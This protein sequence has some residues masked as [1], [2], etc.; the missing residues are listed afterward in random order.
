MKTFLKKIFVPPLASSPVSA[1]AET[2]LGHGIPIFMIHRMKVEGQS[3]N[4]I[5]PD[6]L[7]CC[8]RYLTDKGYTLVSLEDIVLS[9][10]NQISLPVKS[11]A[12]TMD[13]GFLDQAEIAAPLFLEFNC[14]LTFFVITGMLDKKLWPWDAQVSWI[15]DNTKNN[16]L[17]IDFEDELLIMTPGDISGRSKAREEIRNIIKEM[18]SEL[19]P[20]LINKLAEAADVQTPEA[21]PAAYQSMDWDM[22]RELES[23]GVRFAPHSITH[24]ILSKLRNKSVEE[25]IIGS[26]KTLE[27]ELSN[28]LKI[29]CYPTGRVLDFG[30]REIA[31]LKKEN[32]Q[33]AISTVPGY[34]ELKNDRENPVFSLPRLEFPDNITDFIQYCSWIEHAKR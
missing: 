19:I 17:V 30:P 13:D 16:R 24:R 33:A 31:I 8:L 7:R 20:A 1:L 10:N 32:F 22:A 6:H 34:V 9:L 21:T 25:E 28:P 12:F 11:V 18:D 3:N 2:V 15:I 14:P 29:F 5:V 26:W 23:K 27:R 4:G